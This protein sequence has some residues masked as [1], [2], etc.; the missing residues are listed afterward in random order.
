MEAKQIISYLC[1]CTGKTVILM[2][3]KTNCC[4]SKT[5]QQGKLFNVDGS[6]N[7]NNILVYNSN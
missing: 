3:Y 2:F 7:R 5:A 4:S 1:F 6:V